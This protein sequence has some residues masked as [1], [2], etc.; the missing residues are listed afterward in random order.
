MEM[1]GRNQSAVAIEVRPESATAFSARAKGGGNSFPRFAARRR[2]PAQA[3][4]LKKYRCG[5]SPVSKMSDNEHT[6]SSLRNCAGKAVHSDVLSVK[7]SVCE[8][9]PEFCQHPEEGSK[10]SS[11]VRRQDA[12]HVLPNQPAGPIATSN[13]T[14]GKHEVATR[15]AQ[16]FAESR[17]AE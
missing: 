8:P 7:N 3:L 6:P 1:G 10:I 15:I 9:I 13:R 12:G 2:M 4:A 17:D 14:V 11:A 16:S 5:T